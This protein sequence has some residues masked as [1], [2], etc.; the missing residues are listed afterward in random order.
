M[1]GSIGIGVHLYIHTRRLWSLDSY[2]APSTFLTLPLSSFSFN[3]HSAST[4][5]FH[6]QI[7]SIYLLPVG[8][9]ISELHI[10]SCARPLSFVP[11]HDAIIEMQSARGWGVDGWGVD[12][13]WSMR[14]RPNCEKEWVKGID[15]IELA[16]IVR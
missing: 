12:G 14:R 15:R 5:Y 16:R 3:L 1:A 10:L 7:M 11:G 4:T 9:Q 13:G 8:L 6:F 2:W